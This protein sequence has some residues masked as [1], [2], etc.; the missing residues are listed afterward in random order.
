MISL[1]IFAACLAAC[2]VAVIVPGPN[3]TVIFANSLRHGARDG[4]LIGG[5]LGLALARR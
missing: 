4:L 1:D 3:V 5:G 2:I